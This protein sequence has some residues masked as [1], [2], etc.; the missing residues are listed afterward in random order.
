MQTRGAPGGRHSPRYSEGPQAWRACRGRWSRACRGTRPAVLAR[1]AGPLWCGSGGTPAARKAPGAKDPRRLA[2]GRPKR[3]RGDSLGGRPAA[4]PGAAERGFN[5]GKRSR[6]RRSI[7]GR[8]SQGLPKTNL[9]S[10]TQNGSDCT[11]PN[12]D[13]LTRNRSRSGKTIE[14]S[15][16]C[17]V[18]RSALQLRRN[19]LQF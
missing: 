19:Q 14:T 7:R 10:S 12:V 1:W 18:T 9:L 16:A 6:G 8:R 3:A 5:A 15:V 4:G 11:L 17:C 2:R 13:C